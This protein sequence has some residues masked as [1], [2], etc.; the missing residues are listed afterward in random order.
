M[1]RKCARFVSILWG[2]L[3]SWAVCAQ[4]N[5]VQ[6]YSTHLEADSMRFESV[7]E[8]RACLL[9][10]PRDFFGIFF[11]DCAAKDR[12]PELMAVIHEVLA[13]RFAERNQELTVGQYGYSPIPCPGQDPPLAR[14]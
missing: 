12:W 1:N 9:T 5:E 14:R 6:V 10:A 2:L 3:A 7:D 8:L 11:R 13:P 4:T